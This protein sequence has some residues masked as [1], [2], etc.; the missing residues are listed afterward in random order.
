MAIT[1]EIIQGVIALTRQAGSAI[2][3]VFKSAFDVHFKNDNTPVTA[4]DTKAND[5]IIEG[6][7]YGSKNSRPYIL[8]TERAVN[9]D[10][11]IDFLVAEKML[12]NKNKIK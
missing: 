6:L 12:I 11:E 4:A 2:M 3:E 8:P 7:R 10:T 5:I 9:V 1:E